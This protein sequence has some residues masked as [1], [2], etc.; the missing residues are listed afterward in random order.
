ML[1]GNYHNHH[2]SGPTT[3]ITVRGIPHPI[4]A[5]LARS[6]TSKGSLYKTGPLAKGTTELSSGSIP[7]QKAEPI[8]WTHQFGKARIFYTS[9][10][11]EDD[12]KQAAF[13]QL[14]ENAVRWTSEMK[15]AVAARP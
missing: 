15:N 11:H 10:G 7:G 4:L 14:M 13:W 5:G 6:F 12:F 8:A 9:L 1:G 3:T 2:A